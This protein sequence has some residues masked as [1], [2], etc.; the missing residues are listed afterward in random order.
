[1]EANK[2]SVLLSAIY[3]LLFFHVSILTMSSSLSPAVKVIGTRFSAF[4]H[5]AEVALRLKGVP[6]EL[7]TEDL[8]NES[9]LLLKHN[10]VHSKV[11]VLLHGERSIPESLVIVEYVDEAFDGP[12]LLPADPGDRAA[13]RFWAQFLDVKLSQ[14]VSARVYYVHQQCFRLIWL[15]IWMD[16]ETRGGLREGGEGRP[17]QLEGKRFFAGDRIGY[18]DAAASVLT[19]WLAAMEEVAGVKLMNAE[20]YPALCRWAREYTSCEAVKGCLPDWDQLVAVY[21]ANTD[22]FVLVAKTLTTFGISKA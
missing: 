17:G 13:A 15:A 20:E 14:N 2:L 1:M 3:E 11:P 16:G 6:Y 10:P 9:A 18:L 22:K 5:R 21:A 7:I 4:S 12:P 8:N 19:Y